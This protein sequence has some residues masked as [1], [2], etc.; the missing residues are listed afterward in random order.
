MKLIKFFIVGI[1][2]SLI[3]ACSKDNDDTLIVEPENKSLEQLLAEESSQ[4]IKDFFNPSYIYSIVDIKP[5][6]ESR[7]NSNIIDIVK[8]NI[9]LQHVQNPFLEKM[10]TNGGFALWNNAEIIT[11]Y[12]DTE[13][14]VFIPMANY[15]GDEVSG[16]IMAYYNITN[17]G[18][19]FEFYDRDRAL[20]VVLG[21]SSFENDT[22]SVGLTVMFDNDLFD[23]I[24]QIL[25]PYLVNIG[26]GANFNNQNIQN[27]CELELVG[28]ALV[29]WCVQHDVAIKPNSN[30]ST[31]KSQDCPAG[32][33]LVEMIADVFDCGGDGSGGTSGG[34]GG[35]TGGPTSVYE[36]VGGSGSD[37]A[38]CVFCDE[39]GDF[40]S[41]EES[42]ENII[43]DKYGEPDASDLFD[44][45]TDRCDGDDACLSNFIISEEALEHL[46]D[47]IDTAP[48]LQDPIDNGISITSL[49]SPTNPKTFQPGPLIASNVDRTNTEEINS[50]VG[51]DLSA[52]WPVHRP[53]IED[54]EDQELFEAMD[55]LMDYFC[56]GDLDEVS[57][58]YVDAFESNTG[59]SFSHVDLNTFVANHVHT[60]NF[61]KRVGEEINNQLLAANGDFNTLDIDMGDER[62][63]YNTFL[64]MWTGLMILINDTAHA[65]IHLESHTFDGSTG[66]WSA[67]ISIEIKDIFGLD[68]NDISG[69]VSRSL[70]QVHYGFPAWYALQHDRGYE[71]FETKI[72]LLAEI[73]GNINN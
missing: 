24:D 25:T 11:Q 14:F 63:K 13:V 43:N 28:S 64:D 16:S 20:D 18:V 22:L 35:G 55:G 54:A 39:N 62:P 33:I 71:P 19:H 8:Y 2:I 37:I 31:T 57:H 68:E 69:S 21:N 65:K 46:K 6:V 56:T 51:G 23:Y 12:N 17:S 48:E 61:I 49:G 53:F 72:T 73:S 5:V 29:S 67:E 60:Q 10:I 27:R 26:G 34:T 1:F 66:D 58:L 70:R 4:T 7:T 30:T 32:T 15:N 38:E 50:G 36:G 59:N 42:L 45:I 52:I 40:I 9:Y 47:F 41:L 3:C 44:L